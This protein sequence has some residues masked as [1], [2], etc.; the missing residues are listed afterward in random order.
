MDQL[1]E[2]LRQAPPVLEGASW[3]P[4]RWSLAYLKKAVPFLKDYTLAG[5]WHIL[6]RSDIRYRRGRQALH[7]PDPDY[8]RK[9]DEAWA[10]VKKALEQPGRIVTLYLDELSYYRQPSTACCWWDRSFGSAQPLGRLSHRSNTVGRLVGALDV[11]SGQVLW[12][13]A[14][15]IGVRQL[16][17]F[18]GQIRAAYPQAEQIYVIQ[19]NWPVHFHP[20]VEEAARAAGIQMVRLPTYAPW[21]NPIE[22]FWR[23]LRQEVLHMHRWSDQ[24][25]ELH[26]RVETFLRRF[27]EPS[28]SLLRYVG[29]RPE[30]ITEL[31]I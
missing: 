16:A 7:S 21:L 12:R 20:N 2:A 15:K 1:R 22:K 11:L 17:A 24:W 28:P 19:D 8:V 25:E 4:T 30:R 14:S 18:Y 13:R 10:W 31:K 23:W 5:I 29:L 26:R 3:A 6:Q 9:R 27:A